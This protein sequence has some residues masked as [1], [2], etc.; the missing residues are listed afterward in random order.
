MMAQQQ[1][2]ILVMAMASELL[3]SC[4]GPFYNP[5]GK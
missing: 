1:Q 2:I 3:R 4:I 5:N